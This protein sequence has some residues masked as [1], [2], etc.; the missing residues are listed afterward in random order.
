MSVRDQA[1]QLIQQIPD[2]ELI[3]VIRFLR[4]MVVP[5]SR[6]DIQTVEQLVRDLDR[7]RDRAAGEGWISEEEFFAKHDS[8]RT[9]E[10]IDYWGE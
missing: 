6:P 8:G 2:N 3:F 9:Q 5:E 10:S 4:G 1:V 7:A